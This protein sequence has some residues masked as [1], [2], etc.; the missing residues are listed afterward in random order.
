VKRRQEFKRIERRLVGRSKPKT[1]AATSARMA[2]VR[3]RGTAPELLVRR[4]FRSAGLAYR[5]R[6]R[7]LP[8]SPDLANRSRKWAVFVHGCYWHRHN[9][10][11]LATTPKTNAPFWLSKFAHNVARDATARKALR[12]RGFR[13]LTIWQCEAEQPLRLAA[14]LATFQRKGS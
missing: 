7:D 12:G 14:R 2:R 1:D 3:Q 13:V 10:C 8:G 6:N 9:N 5:T 11:R 4:A